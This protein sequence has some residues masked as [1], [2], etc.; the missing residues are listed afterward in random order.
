MKKE[1]FKRY[2]SGIDHHGS[3]HSDIYGICAN[4]GTAGSLWI[5]WVGFPDFAFSL[6]STSPQF[7]FGVDAAPAALVGSALLGLGIEAGSQ[8]AMQIVPAIT[9]LL[10]FGY[11]HFHCFG[12]ESWLIIF[13]H[14]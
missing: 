8:E 6:F 9:F 4:C 13:Q 3:F 11:W 5:V 7:V 12:L 2:R 1:S 14:R 10:H